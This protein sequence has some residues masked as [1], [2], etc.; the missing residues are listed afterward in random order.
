M[1]LYNA[2]AAIDNGACPYCLSLNCRCDQEEVE[3]EEFVRTTVEDVRA[4]FSRP[5][6]KNI[7]KEQP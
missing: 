1:G 3:Q 5:E 4:Y 7:F 6:N 2:I